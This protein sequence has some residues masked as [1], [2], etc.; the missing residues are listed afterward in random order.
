[1]T[2]LSV[3]RNGLTT[4]LRRVSVFALALT[5]G[6]VP[7]I[8]SGC[9]G[10]PA[11]ADEDA[12]AADSTSGPP[13]ERPALAP[14]LFNPAGAISSHDS[15]IDVSSLAQGYVAVSALAKNRLKFQVVKDGAE[16]DYD[17]PGDATPLICPLTMGDGAYKL[18][19]M[20]NTSGDQYVALNSTQADVV[21][22]DEFEPF[23]RP[24]VFCAYNAASAA[25]AKANELSAG[26]RNDG[27]VLSRIYTWITE[28]IS[29]D[30]P[31]AARLADLAGYVPDPDKTLAEKKGVCFDY[32]SLG[33]AMLRSQGIPC[34][35]VT[36][37]LLPDN[38]YHAW[39]VVYLDGSWTSVRLSVDPSTWTRIDLTL[40]AGGDTSAEDG[41]DYI[42]RY[43]Y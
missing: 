16:Y 29:Y 15:M 6:F 31:K 35:I 20:Q 25:V 39:N 22:A 10:D 13:F 23:L 12:T 9:S 37:Y 43:T 8:L 5:L 3:C 34:K 2:P 11:G 38:V 17:L 33:A 30:A 36:G 19:V 4:T 14:A 41:K 21:L 28:N 7:G 1:M 42:N 27:E 26:A 32:A 40:A 24:N 18:S